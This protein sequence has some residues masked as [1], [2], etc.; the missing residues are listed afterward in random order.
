MA[1]A[2]EPHLFETTYRR[3]SDSIPVF[4]GELF[5]PAR[6]L[7]GLLRCFMTEES[8]HRDSSLLSPMIELI[9]NYIVRSLVS[10]DL[11]QMP[12]YDR[13]EVDQAIGYMSSHLSEK[14]TLSKLANYVNLSPTYFTKIFK[15]ITGST[16]NDLLLKMRMQQARKLLLEGGKSITEISLLCGFG[17]P[18]YFSTCFLEQYKISP[19]EY[20]RQALGAK[21]SN[22][23][24]N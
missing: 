14:I 7:L 4:R 2:V 20:L 6:E 19:T 10:Q 21:P 18:S 1:I 23:D 13:M 8:T 17:S 5:T 3:Y 12:I 24:K 11:P 9:V 15:E 16:P 22:M